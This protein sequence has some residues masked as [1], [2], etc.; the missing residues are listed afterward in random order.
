MAIDVSSGFALGMEVAS[1]S[2]ERRKDI[3]DSPTPRFLALDL[4]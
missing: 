2:E 1:F 3:E 4:A